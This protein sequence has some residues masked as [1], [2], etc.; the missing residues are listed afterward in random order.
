MKCVPLAFLLLLAVSAAAQTIPTPPQFLGFEVGADRKLADYRQ[1]RDYFHVLDNTSPRLELQVLGKTTLG[2]EMFMALI[3]SEENLRSHQQR[4]QVD[5]RWEER[6]H[7]A[8][9]EAREKAARRA[10]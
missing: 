1:I 8:R 4:D 9:R 2:E 10:V 3:S 6:C 5:H 7:R